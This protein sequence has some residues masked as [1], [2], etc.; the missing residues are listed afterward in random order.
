[1]PQTNDIMR[2]RFCI[3]QWGRYVQ[4]TFWWKLLQWHPTQPVEEWLFATGLNWLASMDPWIDDTYVI[5]SSRSHNL[6]TPEPDVIFPFYV[7]GVPKVDPVR[8]VDA[9]LWIHRYG[10]SQFMTPRRSSFPVSNLVTAQLRGRVPGTGQLIPVIEFLT[11]EHTIISPTPPIWIGGFINR[12]TGNFIQTSYA[13]INP[14]FR[15]LKTRTKKSSTRLPVP[16]P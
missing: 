5:V 16:V 13:H 9:T 7:S 4:L 14:V 10:I 3:E 6:T 11:L 8:V 15:S 1:M 12:V 2:T